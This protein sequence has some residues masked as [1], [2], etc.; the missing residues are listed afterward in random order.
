MNIPSQPYPNTISDKP[1][2]VCFHDGECPLCN[3]EIKA[4]Q[5]MDKN[6]VIHWVDI[7]R[8]KQALD[9][10]GISYQQAMDN[11]HVLDD[12]QKMIT[13]VK[14]FLVLWQHLPYY[15]RIVPFIQK[16]P[17]LLSTMEAAYRLFARYRLKITGRMQQSEEST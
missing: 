2:A 5:K 13:G 14:G 8:D 6:K 15:R 17:F 9:A 12:E 10:A 3:I 1:K 4:M 7:S 11:I 16:V